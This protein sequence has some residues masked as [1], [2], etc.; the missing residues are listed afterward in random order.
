MGY[1]KQIRRIPRYS[2][3]LDWT[4]VILSGL[5]PLVRL[6]EASD[7]YKNRLNENL[8]RFLAPFSD[9]LIDVRY[10]PNLKF[11]PVNGGFRIVLIKDGNWHE[12]VKSYSTRSYLEVCELINELVDFVEREIEPL[13]ED[14]VKENS[15]L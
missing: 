15:R 14:Y 3:P 2:M 10:Y 12:P 4:A 8:I 7:D 9:W 5:N 13:R 1:I 6:D 11:G